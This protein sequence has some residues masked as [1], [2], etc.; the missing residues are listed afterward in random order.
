LSSLPSQNVFYVGVV[1]E[2]RGMY[3]QSSEAGIRVSEKLR[4]EVYSELRRGLKRIV[5]VLKG[6]RFSLV[7]FH[8]W[9]KIV[10]D[11]KRLKIRLPFLLL[12][13]RLR[14]RV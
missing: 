14:T 3:L 10:G 13:R 9:N 7:Y 1:Y 8:E 12:L 11:S 5:E 6:T 2:G 4:D